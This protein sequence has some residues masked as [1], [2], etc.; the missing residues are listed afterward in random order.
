MS[1]AEENYA[2][3]VKSYADDLARGRDPSE[4]GMQ[5]IRHQIAE[6]REAVEAVAPSP[7]HSETP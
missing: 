4:F 7:S 3:W 5:W 2:Y 1:E 6:W